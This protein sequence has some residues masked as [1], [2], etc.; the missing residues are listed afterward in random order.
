MERS[1][2]L[3]ICKRCTNRSFDASKGIVCGLTNGIAV[4]ERSCPDYI[5][6]EKAI[7]EE[8]ARD[9]VLANTFEARS[10]ARVAKLQAETEH[11]KSQR[12][13]LNNQ[14][15][16]EKVVRTGAN[17]F[18]WIA[19]LSLINSFILLADAR[20]AFVVGLGITQVIDGIILGIAGHYSIWGLIPSL[21]FSVTFIIIGYFANKYSK[22]A[23]ILGMI[24]YG[25]DTL[26][27]FLAPDYL[28]IG[29]HVFALIMIYRGFRYVKK[30]ETDVVAQNANTIETSPQNQQ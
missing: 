18:Y 24:F 26:I 8:D 5:P 19:G 15:D 1:E 25:L 14:I 27:F 30:I 16:P 7:Q 10:K 11:L 13:Y 28:S 4:F 2:H 22:I 17:W 29:F 20:F 6:D 23:F 21:I 12:T 3:K 9:L